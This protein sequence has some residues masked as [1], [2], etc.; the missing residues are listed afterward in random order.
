[1]SVRTMLSIVVMSG[2]LMVSYLLIAKRELSLHVLSNED[3]KPHLEMADA[4]SHKFGR[5]AKTK[6]LNL[7]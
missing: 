6:N 3:S 1:M 2:F 5:V 4:L 7:L